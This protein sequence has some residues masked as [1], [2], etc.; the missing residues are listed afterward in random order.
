MTDPVAAMMRLLAQGHALED[1]GRLD[2]AKARYTEA[3]ALAP[4][5]PRPWLNLGNVFLREGRMS[6]AIAI[7]RKA[8]A[9]D[10]GFA[11][12]RFNL[13]RLLSLDG[14]RAEAEAAFRAA[15]AIDPGFADAAMALAQSQ[16]D[17]G[18]AAEA[19]AT[20]RAIAAAQPR[21]PAV[22]CNLALLLMQRQAF[23]EAEAV[24]L[25]ADASSPLVD[26][27]QGE[28]C[29]RLGRLREAETWLRRVP[30]AD[31]AFPA[32][33]ATLLFSLTARDDLTPERA[34]AIH[35]EYARCLEGAGPAAAAPAP[36][37]PRHRRIRI[38]YLSPDFR[39]HAVALF[40]APVLAHHDRGAF[41]VFCYFTHPHADATTRRLEA[42]T[43]HWRDIARLSDDDA[44]RAIKGDALDVLV[45][46]AGHTTHSRLLLMRHRCAQAQATWLGYLHSTGLDCVD[47]RIC[48]GHTDPPGATERLNSETL[49]RL[50]NSQWCYA[51]LHG[52]DGEVAAAPHAGPPVFGSFNQFWKISDTCVDLWARILREVAGARLRVVGAPEGSAA[53]ALRERFAR[54]GVAADRIELSARV[55]VHRYFAAIGEV[56]VALDTTPYNGATTTL[57]TLWMGVPVVALAGDRASAR[58]GVSL[59]RTLDLPELVA[60]TPDRYVE[61]NVRLA[62]DAAWRGRL[63]GELRRRLLASPLMDGAAFTRALEA[64]YREMLQGVPAAG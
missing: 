24:L 20:L 57:D 1:G 60:D 45:D 43:E 3:A 25:Q 61:L 7:T 46:L 9:L 14:Q 17:A 32:A 28:L 18:N 15:L 37:P 33:A 35:R 44:V 36:A 41:E 51:P 23:D 6:D 12:A 16:E 64:R 53:R 47:Y 52:A 11:P 8:V 27:A 19:E 42:M 56:D 34:Y 55:D 40:V 50:P 54:R 38:G 29:V 13:G 39:Q 31:P 63:R 10:A 2:D 58:S 48:D 30:P 62:T 21:H 5:H 59:L 26:A 49:V 4:G 22:G